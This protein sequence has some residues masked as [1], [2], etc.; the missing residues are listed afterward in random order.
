[1]SCGCIHGAIVPG[2]IAWIG[3]AALCFESRRRES[4]IRIV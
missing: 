4:D 2:A 3:A 1:M